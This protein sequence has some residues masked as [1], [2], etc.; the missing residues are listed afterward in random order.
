LKFIIF[1][2]TTNSGIHCVTTSNTS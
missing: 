2:N 1:N